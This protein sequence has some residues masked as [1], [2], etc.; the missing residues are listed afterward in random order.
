STKINAQL[1]GLGKASVNYLGGSANLKLKVNPGTTLELVSGPKDL[2]AL[3]RLGIAAGILTAPKTDSKGNPI[4]TNDATTF[5][6]GLSGM[7]DLSTRTG[8]NLARSTLLTM[9]S[10]LQ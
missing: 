6:L 9:L 7:L 2:D 8:A 5:G 3:A 10:S 1:G 4:A